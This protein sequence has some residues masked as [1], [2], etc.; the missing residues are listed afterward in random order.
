MVA[1]IRDYTDSLRKAHVLRR[2]II[3]TFSL[4][5]SSLL[6]GIFFLWLFPKL[7]I[8][9]GGMAKAQAYMLSA[10]KIMTFALFKGDSVREG[11][12]AEETVKKIVQDRVD[13]KYL[14][15]GG[16][17]TD[18]YIRN[19]GTFANK[20]I[21]PS[22][23]D[24]PEEWLARLD[25][26]V[27]STELAMG[28]FSSYDEITTTIVQLENGKY[29]PINI[30]V[31]PSDSLPSLL[32][33]MHQVPRISLDQLPYDL[34]LAQRDRALRLQERMYDLRA[35]Y[36][37]FVIAQVQRFEREFVA[38]EG[39]IREDVK[40]S[41]IKDAWVRHSSLYDNVMLWG[42]YH[43]GAE[44]GIAPEWSEKAALVKSRLLAEYWDEGE[45]IFFDEKPTYVGQQ[46]FSADNLIAFDFGLLNPEVE[47]ERIYLER[48]VDY[49][50]RKDLDQPFPL[51]TTELRKPEK[52][53]LP[54][55]IFAPNYIGTTIW[56]YWGMA[57]INLL[58]QLSDYYPERNFDL[59]A[60]S[61][62]DA[63]SRNIVRYG[64]VPELYH[65]NGDQYRLVFYRSVNDMIWGIY[66][67]YLRNE[68]PYGE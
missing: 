30:Y 27:R 67:L 3:W 59:T 4:L 17:Y 49:V 22:S 65:P 23:A 7:P 8:S 57:Y 18:F 43:Y 2:G 56:S 45:G 6:I 60:R 25:L 62:L 63:Y 36:R 39:L 32:R 24:N 44:T 5:L 37:D 66:Y 58:E 13:E 1:Q 54:V 14:Y 48:I 47:T 10:R 52:E 42:M 40:L 61:F 28:V 9:G 41:G 15:T 68:V 35:T 21:D 34:T 12:N 51:A 50:Q 11:V 29:V 26:V 46:Y 53:H 64:G 20:L 55:R 16:H 31:A 19:L 38:S 33:V